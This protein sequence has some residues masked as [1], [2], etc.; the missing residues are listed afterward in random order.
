MEKKIFPCFVTHVQPFSPS[1]MPI[2]KIASVSTKKSTTPRTDK[3]KSTS[4][5][6][7]Q[8]SIT[9]TTTTTTTSIT[10]HAATNTTNTTTEH[11]VKKA[12]GL[13]TSFFSHPLN[14]KQ[15]EKTL[16]KT[17]TIVVANAD[18]AAT[19][20]SENDGTRKEEATKYK[21]SGAE[22]KEEK[23][24]PTAEEG[25]EAIFQLDF[26][27]VLTEG[28]KQQSEGHSNA[29]P[30]G[31]EFTKKKDKF[32][33]FQEACKEADDRRARL[34]A[35]EKNVA[36]EKEHS[37][38]S[39]ITTATASATKAT[40]SPQESHQKP[41]ASPGRTKAERRRD[42]EK[43]LERMQSQPAATT[44]APQRKPVVVVVV[45]PAGAL[46]KR[47]NSDPLAS[48][49]AVEAG[50]KGITATSSAE[51]MAPPEAKKAKTAEDASLWVDKYRP[52]TLKD[53]IY[54]SRAVVDR[55]LRW[56]EAWKATGKPP[57]AKGRGKGAWN[58]SARAVLISGPPG[59]GKTTTALLACEQVGM[60]PI[61]LNASDTRSKASIKDVV[62]EALGNTSIA[63]FCQK[64]KRKVD[65]KSVI[66]MDEVDGM[67][68]GDRGGIAELIAVVKKTRVPVICI[69][70]DRASTK[71]RSLAAHCVDLRFQKP[72]PEQVCTR[73]VRISNAE[74]A[75]LTMNEGRRIAAIANCD[76]R[77]AIHLLYLSVLSSRGG[78][79]IT[80]ALDN[81]NSSSNSGSGN[82]LAKDM[83]MN[84][85]DVVPRIF[86]YR[87]STLDQKVRFYF[88]DYAMVPLLVQENYLSTAPALSG[89]VKIAG[90]PASHIDLVSRAAD[91]L[92]VA[93][94]LDGAIRRSGRWDLLTEHACL[95]TVYPA[96]QVQS[97]SAQN[98]K[99]K[100]PAWLGKNSTRTKNLRVL[101]DI[102]THVS[103][104][105]AQS[106]TQ[107]DLVESGYLD[108]LS[109]RIV[110]PMTDTQISDTK[111]AAVSQVTSFMKSYGLDRAD[112]EAVCELSFC[113]RSQD[114]SGPT[115][116]AFTKRINAMN[117][118]ITT[119]KGKSGS[120]R[121]LLNKADGNDDGDAVDYDDTHQES[122]ESNEI[123]MMN[124]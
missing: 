119:A 98:M 41:K 76:I 102:Q 96:Y 72:L 24:T 8:E 91:A 121:A 54:G 69:C 32:I 107:N 111:E 23:K 6:S 117:E 61:E 120:A 71:I 28:Q 51:I 19:T 103:S 86:A 33:K 12:P 99:L 53:V 34:E 93:D 75:D 25:E 1:S 106:M 3:R 78:K 10:T 14:H 13:L 74:H 87:G 43:L 26:S 27:A 70:N 49:K 57:E 15:D 63:A 47:I 20:N 100:F 115:K 39:S 85:F 88:S 67:S 36:K 35:E 50:S 9:T 38:V 21:R 114:I 110:D 65:T 109:Q 62:E 97:P 124:V 80:Q 94:V 90:K 64:D 79:T 4:S 92:S 122:T 116:A 68:S 95:S 18:S 55:L 112:W 46:K 77:Q 37:T 84:P 58:D 81:S 45:P 89:V 108:L 11:T 31:F 59:I 118:E 29:A 5:K 22:K 30:P 52:R 104:A 44:T 42:T 123:N 16:P 48:A 82:S 17:D 101:K 105:T 83:D 73:L 113:D 7:Q 40:P 66:I 56:L 60:R 2:K